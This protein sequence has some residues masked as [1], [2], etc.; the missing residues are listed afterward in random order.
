MCHG[1]IGNVQVSI[2][3]KKRSKIFSVLISFKR[4]I[5][6]FNGEQKTKYC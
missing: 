1:R 6:V 4:S 3:T 5:H 2:K